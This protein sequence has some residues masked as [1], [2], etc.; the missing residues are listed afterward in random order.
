[1]LVKG[2]GPIPADVAA[3]GEG[4]GKVEDATGRPFQGK[5]GELMNF[6]LFKAG[7]NRDK[8]WVDNIVPLRCTD[9]DGKDRAPNEFE[10]KQHSQRFRKILEDVNPRTILAI[11]RTATRWFLGDV[12][13]EAVH[14]IPIRTGNRVVIPCYHTAAALHD[15]SGDMAAYV[16]HDFQQAGLFLKGQIKARELKDAHPQPT[17]KL[18]RGGAQVENAFPEKAPW[19]AP[20]FIDT[21]GYPDYPFSLQ[22]SFGPGH[23]FMI[24]ADDKE[25]LE[26]F[27][28]CALSYTWVIHNALY[29]LRLLFDMGIDLI[30][31]G[32]PF[33]DSMVGAYLT[34]L[35]PQG[36]KPLALRYAGMRMKSYEDLT[37]SYERKQIMDWLYSALEHEDD[38]LMPEPVL[39]RDSKTGDFRVRQPQHPGRRIRSILTDVESGKIDKQTGEIVSPMKRYGQVEPQ[40]RKLI[41]AEAGPRPRFH[42][43]LLPIEEVVAYGCRDTDATARVYPALWEKMKALDLGDCYQMKRAILPMVER[44]MRVGFGIDHRHFEGMRAD[45]EREQDR[46]D[47]EIKKHTGGKWLNVDSNPQVAALLFD[48]LGLDSE[49]RTKK[50]RVPSTDDKALEGLVGRHPAIQLIIDRRELGTID[51]FARDLPVFAAADSRIHCTLR[52]TRVAQ[53]RLAASKPNLLGIPVRT[54]IGKRLRAGF[55]AGYERHLGSA[56]L[57]QIEMLVMADKSQDPVLIHEMRSGID[58]H[59]QNAIDL[60][61]APPEKSKDPNYREPA[62]R[63]GFGVITGITEVGLYEQLR[64]NHI[65]TTV[66]QCREILTGYMNKYKGIDRY[67]KEIR[68]KTRQLGYVRDSWGMLRYLPGVWSDIPYVRAEAERQSH[69][70]DISG[71]AQG[72]IQ[73]AMA[74]IWQRLLD[75]VWPA[76]IHCEI[77]LQIH[78]ELIWEGEGEPDGWQAQMISELITEELTAES[79]LYAVP[80]KAKATTGKTWGELK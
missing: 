79:H 55:V 2:E 38:M 28:A 75:E 76:G 43:G 21:E 39:E 56:D 63:A 7:I 13:M 19:R 47:R 51:S 34:R 73:R 48:R 67:I 70:H 23:G 5:A 11:G 10:I 78:D 16:A 40:I 50:G 14:G 37:D 58:V 25:G 49:R 32:I 4:P 72:I 36:L 42:L 68:R 64:L 54:D 65:D 57:S 59:A 66:N 52:V 35:D 17:Y 30:A 60:L 8:I 77:L 12:D 74:R 22:F 41:E 45:I 27:V 31:L 18:L 24:L 71:T 46:L 3:I 61:H 44:M 29:D 80:L 53:G 62:K 15:A 9:A 69:S 33:D 6:H 26:R 20:I 1:M